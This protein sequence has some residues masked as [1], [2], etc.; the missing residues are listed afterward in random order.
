MDESFFPIG[1]FAEAFFAP[2][3]FVDPIS[4]PVP[5]SPSAGPAGGGAG[6]GRKRQESRYVIEKSETLCVYNEQ[7]DEAELF[8][9]LLAFLKTMEDNRK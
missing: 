9:I 5:P 3:Y 8:T 6:G 4:T 2:Q 1:F 7:Q